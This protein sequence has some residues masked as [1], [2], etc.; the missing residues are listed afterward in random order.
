MSVPT[1]VGSIVSWAKSAVGTPALP[2]QW[3]ECNGQV[4]STVGS[5]YFG[6]A[7]PNLNG[8]LGQP[9]RFTRGALASGGVGGADSVALTTPELPSHTHPLFY[10]TLSVAG[11]AV[12]IVR[13]DSGSA[14][15]T[16]STGSGFAHENRPAF[17]EVVFIIRVL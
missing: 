4:C 16:G 6:L 17:Y 14:G 12:Q 11:G 3:E 9:Q 10:N 15:V 1:P 5:P 8:A 13:N 7:L 2:G